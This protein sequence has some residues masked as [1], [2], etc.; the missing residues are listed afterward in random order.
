MEIQAKI[1]EFN[2]GTYEGN[3]YSNVLVRYNGKILKFK[4]N[5]QADVD[6]SASDVDKDVLLTLEIVAGANFSA[7][8]R[9]VAVS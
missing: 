9:I 8:P 6:L 4:I 2:E 5:S 3:K 1:L 7:T